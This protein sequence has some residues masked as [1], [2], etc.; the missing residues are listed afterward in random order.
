MDFDTTQVG[1]LSWQSAWH[2]MPP[3]MS[4]CPF[5]TYDLDYLQIRC[6][7]YTKFNFRVKDYLKI[8]TQATSFFFF[9][10]FYFFLFFKKKN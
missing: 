6:H 8:K 10:F 7:H 4:M 3:L 9:F 5:K 1:R 2:G